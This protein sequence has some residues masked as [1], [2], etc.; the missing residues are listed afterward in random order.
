MPRAVGVKWNP[1]TAIFRGNLM[2]DQPPRPP[3]GIDLR[4]L[5]SFADVVR[6][7]NVFETTLRALSIELASGSPLE[8]A[9]TLLKGLEAIRLG[10]KALPDNLRD[11]LPRAA[12]L[13][14]LVRLVNAGQDNTQSL[15]PFVPHL[16]LLSKAREV[17][18]HVRQK[19]DEATNKLFELFF[20]GVCAACGSDLVLA[21][22]EHSKREKHPDILITIKKRRW[23]FECKVI[24]GDSPRSWFER[25]ED[26]AG[27]IQ[28]C[29]EAEVG[30][31]VLN[32]KNL[33]H[34]DDF[35]PVLNNEAYRAGQEAPEFG[36]WKDRKTLISYLGACGQLRDQQL[37]QMNVAADLDQLFANCKKVLPAAIFILPTFAFVASATGPL[38]TPIHMMYLAPFGRLGRANENV[39][40][41]LNECLHHRL[42]ESWVKRWINTIRSMMS[43]S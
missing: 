34:P 18:Q 2:N 7:A 32:L 38:A 43:C 3:P 28:N 12:G 27:Q 13:L 22:P 9:L 36:V 5:I 42:A 11:D 39:L 8:E 4:D 35:L 37:R 17:S 23:A 19:G 14:E 1:T 6:T 24:V 15:A 21:D 29:A 30:C 33:L 16:R 26:G 10:H 40:S 31:V 25:L 41:L 20:G